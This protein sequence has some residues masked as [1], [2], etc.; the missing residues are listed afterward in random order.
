MLLA[1]KSMSR[2]PC[3]RKTLFAA[4]N[5]SIDMLA[6]SGQ[7]RHSADDC[8]V[9]ATLQQRVLL[10]RQLAARNQRKRGWGMKRTMGDT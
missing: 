4:A 10:T 5:H 7:S 6:K 2:W 8:L 1:I 3:K 9:S